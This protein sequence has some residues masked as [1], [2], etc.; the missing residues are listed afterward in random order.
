[1]FYILNEKSVLICRYQETFYVAACGLE[2]VVTD[3]WD[4]LITRIVE[5]TGCEK[6]DAIAV[7]S[8]YFF[9]FKNQW[10]IQLGKCDNQLL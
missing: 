7:A 5:M 6:N 1:M 10:V 8:D 9:D 4:Y 2:N 3:K